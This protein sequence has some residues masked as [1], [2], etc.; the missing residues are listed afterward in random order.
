MVHIIQTMRFNNREA[1]QIFIFLSPHFPPR[2]RFFTRALK[3]KGV[4]VLGIGD[5]SYENLHQELK[6]NLCEYFR[7]SN[8]EDYDQ[9]YRA[10]G[11]FIHRYGRINYIESLNEH[12]QELEARL[13]EDF[14]VEGYRPAQMDRFKRKS[15]MKSIFKDAGLTVAPGLRPTSLEEAVQFGKNVGYPLIMKPDIGVGAAGARKAHN[16]AE[17]THL[18]DKNEDVYIEK[19][20]VGTIETYDGLTDNQGNIV[21]YS[22][23]GYAGGIM[24]M[25]NGDC[26]SCFF[27]V[28]KDVPAD[29]KEVGDKA[30][31]AFNV[32]SRFFHVEFFRTQEGTLLPLEMNLRPP[33]GI[34]VDL[35][36]YAH[37]TDMYSNY[38]NVIT[39]IPVS[40]FKKALHNC[41]YAG[42]R[43]TIK[44]KYTHQ[45]VVKKFGNKLELHT[46]MP[47]V[48][49]GVMGNEA[50]VFVCETT[51]EMKM[52][53][54]FVEAR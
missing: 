3:Q 53:I 43:N 40:P 17:L 18:Y 51:D 48:F 39:K 5:E 29:L 19:F 50:Y 37:R 10:V 7:V 54:D 22:S 16:E 15:C 45:E 42:R 30:V 41:V 6:E 38:A 27:Y 21:F 14:N 23:L 46:H 35:W 49:S 9:V 28:K 52:Y 44:Y 47:E 36:N 12:W 33:G 8:M 1:H 13:R 26:S 11:F 31:K 25:L 32:K 20:I 34:T 24:E 4:T 2:F